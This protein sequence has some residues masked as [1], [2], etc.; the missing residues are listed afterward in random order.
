MSHSTMSLPALYDYAKGVNNVD[1]FSG[2]TLPSSIDASTLKDWILFRSAPFELLY[3]NPVYMQSAITAWSMVHYRTFEKWAKALAID[4]DPL[5]N[6]DR[7][8]VMTASDLESRTRKHTGKVED[9][10]SESNDTE[11]ARKGSS[12]GSTVNSSKNKTTGDNTTTNSVSAFDSAS[13]QNK[14]KSVAV[15]GGTGSDQGVQATNGS[16]KDEA[17]TQTDRVNNKTSDTKDADIDNAMN[18]RSH[19]L[20]A[21]GNIGVT[22]SQQMLQSELDIDTWNLYEHI[23]DMFLDEFCVLLY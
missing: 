19:K 21:F 9:L 12:A 23:T 15:T 8:E 10:E 3:P 13:F 1:I 2:M 6:Y 22:T 4:Y 20:R 17:S 16:D 7:T 18:S 11:Y 5:N 14:D